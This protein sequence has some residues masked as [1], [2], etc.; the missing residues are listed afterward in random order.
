M[1]ALIV[2]GESRAETMADSTY[3]QFNPNF[4]GDD[5]LVALRYIAGND[6]S[7]GWGMRYSL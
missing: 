7:W 4:V 1:A 5:P 6:E 2:T 3:S